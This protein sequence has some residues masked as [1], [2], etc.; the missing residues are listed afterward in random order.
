MLR[1]S[2]DFSSK[3]NKET[4]TPNCLRWSFAVRSERLSSFLKCLSQFQELYSLEQIRRLIWIY[5]TFKFRVMVK[6]SHA[7]GRQPLSKCCP[8]ST[9]PLYYLWILNMLISHTG[10]VSLFVYRAELKIEFTSEDCLKILELELCL[11]FGK[12]STCMS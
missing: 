1:V 3:F 2:L 4:F 11:L 7:G 8:A 9:H 10:P 6:T 12:G 5:H